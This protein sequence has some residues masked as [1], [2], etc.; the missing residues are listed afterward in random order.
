MGL[1]LGSKHL[2]K[3]S[4]VAA[5]VALTV[6]SSATAT[7]GEELI[8]LEW[9]PDAPTVDVGDP[10]A[11]GL[12]AYT[13]PEELQLFRALDMV[14]TWDPTYL[15]LDGLDDSGAVELLSSGFPPNDAYGLNETVPPQ[16]GDGYYRAWAPLGNPIEVSPGGILLTTFEF[17]ALAPT[18]GTLVDIAVSGGSPVLDTT[19]WG[20]PD[21]NTIVTGTLGETWVQ[22]VPEPA[23]LTLLLCGFPLLRRRRPDAE[24]CRS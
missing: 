4:A 14:F 12:W 16:D 7:A 3:W 2:R 24:S 19:I 8:N 1:T 5:V 15:Q 20:G 13:N 21:A 10:V 22:I 17:T 23:T 6:L 11:L 18:D 9:R